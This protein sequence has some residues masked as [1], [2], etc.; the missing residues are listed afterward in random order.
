M[1]FSSLILIEWKIAPRAMLRETA[2][3][4]ILLLSLGSFLLCLLLSG[5]MNRLLSGQW[6]VTAI[7]RA[8]VPAAE[9][10]GI[11]KKAAGLPGVRSAAYKDPE[12]AW[13]EFLAA[14]PGLESL[15]GGAG[16][17]PLP[18]HVEI[19][20]RPDRFTEADIRAVE[21]ALRPLPHVEK[22]LYGGEALAGLLRIREWVNAFFWAGFALLCGV[23]F[24]I[25]VLQEKARCLS[26]AAD[27]EFLRERGV[28]ARTLSISRASAAV[29]TGFLLAMA[30]TGASA[31][32]LFLLESRLPL[33][34]RVIG[35][36][37]EILTPSVF[38]PLA[39]F[40]FSAA[41]ASG[42][43]SSLHWSAVQSPRK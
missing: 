8:S 11:A 7:L 33:L 14:Y 38:I 28:P 17:N 22:I 35:P 23:T 2:G 37:A 1:T 5:G 36:A 42:A 41:I 34:V 25:F 24:L 10:E 29:L 30:A 31:L 13:N 6:T 15:R 4:F 3:R 18:G 12:A 20:M 27:F 9:G 32:L 21:A 26:L 39:M 16:G 43:A 19:R 40:L